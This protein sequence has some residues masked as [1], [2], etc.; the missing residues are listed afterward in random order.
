MNVR[1]LEHY[2][3][4]DWFVMV[5]APFTFT[6]NPKPLHFGNALCRRFAAF[7]DKVVHVVAD[8]PDDVW[9]RLL[10]SASMAA[11]AA[12]TAVGERP[13]LCSLASDPRQQLVQPDAAAL[14]AYALQE[15]LTGPGGTWSG[16][17]LLWKCGSGMRTCQH[18][19]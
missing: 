1:F 18:K 16:R 7:A 4:V 17:Y 5:E 19:D 15:V 12:A 14:H 13:R 6:G 8:F 10:I 2:D 3:A 9:R 11:Q